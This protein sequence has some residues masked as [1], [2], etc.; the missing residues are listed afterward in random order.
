M[1]ELAGEA[2]AVARGHSRD[3]LHPSTPM[4]RSSPEPSSHV[5]FPRFSV[6]RRNL[7]T[8]LLHSLALLWRSKRLRSAAFAEPRISSSVS[9]A[10]GQTTK[11]FPVGH[12]NPVFFAFQMSVTFRRGGS[13]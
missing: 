12:P 2:A 6:E 8:A 13:L 5:A 11:F 7:P 10:A 9:S 4:A 1:A 3:L